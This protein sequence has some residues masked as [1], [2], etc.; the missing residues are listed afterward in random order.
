M[1]TVT[2]LKETTQNPITLIG[3][4]AGICCRADISNPEANYRR[5]ID[6]IKSN[7]GR[8]LE[9]PNVEIVL[10]G[11]S[12]KVIREWYTHIGGMPTRLQA[13]TRYI[14]Y[15][16]F[17]YV[18]PHSIINT[19]GALEVYS[20]IMSS[21]RSGITKLKE[22]GVPNEDATMPL[23]LA[24]TTMIVDKRDFRNYIDMSRNRKCGRAY[25][26]FREMLTDIEMALAKYSN[27]WKTLIEMTMKPKCEVLGY[28]PEKH[29]CGRHK[30]K[31]EQA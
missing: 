30:Q 4:R 29:S 6:C 19:Y 15:S 7:H 2:I 13:S 24:M 8:T 26:E 22:L 14:D 20:G 28:C 9:F 31:G 18:I 23:P 3:E 12:A 10:D 27:E 25:W 1:G 16:N 17:D 5:G 21:I 11:Y